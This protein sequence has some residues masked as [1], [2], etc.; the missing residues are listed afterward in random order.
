MTTG[1]KPLRDCD[2]EV[3]YTLDELL[4]LKDYIDQLESAEGRKGLQFEELQTDA[5]TNVQSLLRNMEKRLLYSYK[6][7]I[8]EGTRKAFA[9]VAKPVTSLKEFTD[10]P[11]PGLFNSI[12]H[13]MLDNFCSCRA[14][15]IS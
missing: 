7:P 8:S 4:T 14:S 6:I 1:R 2:Y 11:L 9:E 13:D 10:N 12:L 5:V 15:R 3:D